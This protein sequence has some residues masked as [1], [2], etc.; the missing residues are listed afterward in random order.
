MS[1]EPERNL[2]MELVRVT[3]TAALASARWMG[4]RQKE[5]GDGAAVDGMRLMLNAIDMDGT[6]IIGEGEKDEAP[7]LYNGEK[8]GNRNGPAMD[9]AVDPVEGTTLLAKGQPNAIAVIAASPA[10]TMWNPGPGFYMKKMV[11][12]RKARNAIS[13]ELSITENLYNVAKALG[14][15]VE[16][17]TVFTL[18]RPRHDK[19]IEEISTAGARVSLHHDGD[20]AGSLMAAFPNQSTIDM[21]ITIGGTP[22][23]VIT[24]C[25]IKALGGQFLGQLDPQSVEELK[26]VQKAGLDVDQILTV[27]DIV[28]SDDVFFAA[29]G[30]TSPGHVI[31]GVRYE[32]DGI[33]T[34]SIVIRGKSGTIRY[35]ESIHS[36]EKLKTISAID[37]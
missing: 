37:Y 9:L 26:L 11:V 16:D 33:H 23:G 6:I 25:A 27:D 34:H 22:E 14:K 3:E 35:I 24:A 36:L 5:K 29:T 17:L 8:V 15:R 2:G 1:K 20:V 30:I 31:K 4:R 10:G 7:M 21:M 32:S 28:K 18:E 19:I 13:F 12:G